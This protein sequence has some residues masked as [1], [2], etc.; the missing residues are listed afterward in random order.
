MA[1]DH[2]LLGVD[3]QL[4]ERWRCA[5]TYR[6]APPWC[7][8]GCRG[9]CGG[10]GAAPRPSIIEGHGIPAGAPNRLRQ[11]EILLVAGQ[12][13]Q[14]HHGRVGARAGRDIGDAVDRHPAARDAQHLHARWMGRIDG[15][16]GED[17]RR[18]RRVFSRRDGA[19][20][21]VICERGGQRRVQHKRRQQD[22]EKQ[23]SCRSPGFTVYSVSH[24]CACWLEDLN[25]PGGK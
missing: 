4:L 25:R 19:L 16:V 3:L 20:A 11:I 18:D 7:P 15:R 12:A 10:P 2:Q 21:A 8:P 13:V 9:S 22:L 14:Q 24:V 17:R 6:P 5:R 23:A 1:G